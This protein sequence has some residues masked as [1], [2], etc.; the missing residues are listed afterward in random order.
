MLEIKKYYKSKHHTLNL[1]KM[2]PSRNHFDV[3]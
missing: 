3:E 2:F 1:Q